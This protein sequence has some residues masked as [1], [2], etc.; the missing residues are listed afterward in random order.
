MKKNSSA[1]DLNPEILWDA[2]L[3]GDEDM[4]RGVYAQLDESQHVSV[5][6]HLQ[7]MMSEEGWHPSQRESALVALN[8]IKQF[9]SRKTL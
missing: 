2:V 1:L 4:I 9:E 7:K 6:A 8:T 3:S 5:K